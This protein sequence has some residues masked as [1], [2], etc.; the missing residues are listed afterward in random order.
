L[1]ILENLDWGGNTFATILLLVIWDLAENADLFIFDCITALDSASPVQ[2]ISITM[3]VC[4]SVA[5]SKCLVG[6]TLLKFSLVV[7]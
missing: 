1:K 4:A 5:S 3:V 6:M 2:E 7:Q